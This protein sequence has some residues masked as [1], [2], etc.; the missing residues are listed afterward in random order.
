MTQ[1]Q[2]LNDISVKVGRVEV[3]QEVGAKNINDLTVTV[4]RLVEKFEVNND[5]AREALD[6]SKSAHRRLDG[7]DR[8]I[9]WGGTTVI[10]AVVLSVIAFI[11]KG[12]LAN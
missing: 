6:K 3:L 5:I 7:I 12:G 9:F 2:Q 4:Q 11:V 10:G 8:I 1:E